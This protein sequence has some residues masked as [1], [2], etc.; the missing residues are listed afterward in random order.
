ML[1]S[2]YILVP[3]VLQVL[4]M[5]GDEL[6]FHRQRGLPRWERWGHPLDTLTALLC[7]LW[8]W[9]VPPSGQ[10]VAVYA[11]LAL[12]SSLFITKDEWVHHHHC[13]AGEHWLHALLFVLHP[14]VLLGAGLLWPAAHGQ[15]SPWLHWAGWERAFLLGNLLLM[16]SFGLYQLI[17]WNLLWKPR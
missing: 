17:Y 8:L 4:C 2:R 12:F 5:G 3:F 14:L 11:G 6:Y 10:A 9:F 15:V 13:P 7:L 16:S 1:D